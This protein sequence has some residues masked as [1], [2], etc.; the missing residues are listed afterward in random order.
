MSAEKEKQWENMTHEEKQD[1]LFRQQKD[2]A[3]YPLVHVNLNALKVCRM[4]ALSP[5]SRIFTISL[6]VDYALQ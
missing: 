1:W 3:T 2:L 5:I 6:D 4:K